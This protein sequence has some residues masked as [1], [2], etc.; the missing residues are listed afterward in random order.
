MY[1]H[2]FWQIYIY[3][4]QKRCVCFVSTH[5]FWQIH[6][7]LIDFSAGYIS[8][9]FLQAVFSAFFLYYRWVF[10][11]GHLAYTN[12][13]F[14]IYIYLY[15]YVHFFFH[16]QLSECFF[17]IIDDSFFEVIQCIQTCLL[18]YIYI[19][20]YIYIC[21]HRQSSQRFHCLMPV[22]SVTTQKLCSI[23]S[24]GRCVAVRC[25][26][27][28]S[29]AVCC[30]VLYCVAEWCSVLQCVAL[31]CRVVQCVAFCCIVLRSG[32]VCCSVLHCVA[33]WCSVLQCVAVCCNVLQCVEHD[34]PKEVCNH[35]TRQVCCSVL[36]CVAEWCCVLQCVSMTTQKK[37]STPVPARYVA[38]GC[39]VLQG[40]AGCCRV[41]QGVSEYVAIWC[42][43]MLQYDVGVCCNMMLEYV[44]ICW[45]MLQYD[46]MLLQS[47]CS[48]LQCFCI[49]LSPTT[50][51][52]WCTTTG[53]RIFLLQ[54]VLST[55]TWLVYQSVLQCVAACSIVLRCV[56][57]RASCSIPLFDRVL[58][59]LSRRIDSFAL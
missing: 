53:G 27:L 3:I 20:I 24:P 36:Q 34:H 48:V 37:S 33:E 58:L 9:F 38:G 46:A 15:I 44:A 4:C 39:R 6:M 52:W 45:S 55:L 1:P 30:N 13:S 10:F 2:L 41:L 16:R 28:R 50:Q 40:V 17:C 31:C 56:T 43:S 54:V 21:F 49:V 51:A 26:V 47:C 7:F 8:F 18:T 11:W 25:I 5:L 29:G 19:H 42:W 22:R 23:L 32:A 57:P 12:V 35:F 59:G 14:D